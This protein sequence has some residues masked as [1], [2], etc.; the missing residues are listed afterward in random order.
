MQGHLSFVLI[1]VLLT[2]ALLPAGA[3]PGKTA[4]D[5][6]L[7]GTSYFLPD[8]L[9]SVRQVANASGMVGDPWA[10]D[11]FG[12]PI[13]S[14][15]SSVYGF[16]GEWT[17]GSGLQYLRVRYYSPEQGRFITRDPF[18]GY[19][20]QPSTLNPYV[21]SINNHNVSINFSIAMQRTIEF[22]DYHVKDQ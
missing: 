11:P 15:G 4:G 20:K 19:M 22:F 18:P 13:G 16:A 12:N 3:I 8:G 6:A 14:S 9:G 17:D 10:F 2:Q 7:S 1:I 21:Y 5:G